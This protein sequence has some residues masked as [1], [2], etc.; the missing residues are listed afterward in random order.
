MQ[1]IHASIDSPGPLNSLWYHQSWYLMLYVHKLYVMY[2]ILGKRLG[3]LLLGLEESKW[4]CCLNWAN[5]LPLPVWIYSVRNVWAGSDLSFWV[6]QG[7]Q[8]KLKG[9]WMGENKQQLTAQTYRL[10][11]WMP[12]KCLWCWVS[13]KCHM[14]LCWRSRVISTGGE[15]NVSWHLASVWGRQLMAPQKQWTPPYLG[16]S[17]TGWKTGGLEGTSSLTGNRNESTGCCYR[18]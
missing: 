18:A 13:Q 11:C 10:Q 6:I 8:W 1:V 9:I 7:R 15:P 12:Q 17:G 3:L 16:G 4:L 2:H 5:L 14:A